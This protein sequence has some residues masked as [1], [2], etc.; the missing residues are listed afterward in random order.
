[1]GSSKVR[2][3]GVAG[4]TSLAM[5]IRTHASSPLHPRAR[6]PSCA[7]RA[8]SWQIGGNKERCVMILLCR[9][10]Q[11]DTGVLLLSLLTMH[12]F[13]QMPRQTAPSP[14]RCCPGGYQ[15]RGRVGLPRGKRRQRLQWCWITAPSLPGSP[16]DFL[17]RPGCH[18]GCCCER[19]VVQP[20]RPRLA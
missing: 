17:Q 7:L 11:L 5:R 14:S 1:M 19:Y 12:C 4:L 9:T 16:H 18:R 13:S 10:F 2:G 3:C 15:T 20:A 6:S 8:T